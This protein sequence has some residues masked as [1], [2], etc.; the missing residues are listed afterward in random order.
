M[1]FGVNPAP[2][3]PG[4]APKPPRDGDKE[5][6]R[7]RINVEVRMGRRPHPN[8][9][10]CADCGHVWEPGARRHEYDHHLGYAA[11]HHYDVE[12]V[13]TVCH[14]ARGDGRGELIQVRAAGG[15]YTTKEATNG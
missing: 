12:P 6:A 13:C 2:G 9:L 7:Q 1:P 11:A 5:Q 8:T 10:P 3:R 14:R 4:P 15:R